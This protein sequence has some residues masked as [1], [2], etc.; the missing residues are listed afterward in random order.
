MRW[1]K[2][3]PWLSLI[4]LI[5]TYSLAGWHYAEWTNEM[6]LE[7]NLWLWNME[8]AIAAAVVN[9]IAVIGV[10]AISNIVNTPFDSLTMGLGG[11]LKTEAKAVMSIFIG[12]L[13]FAL[14]VQRLQHFVRFLILLSAFLL[15]KLDLR[16]AGYSEVTSRILLILFSLGSFASGVASFYQLSVISYQ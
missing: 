4:I 10:F 8:P 2:K 1:L 14:I 15:F 7:G 3:F 13:A 11:W 5:A 6:I 16:N 12:A 9:G